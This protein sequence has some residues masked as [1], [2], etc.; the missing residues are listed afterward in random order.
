MLISVSSI[1]QTK[2]YEPV[3]WK[4]QFWGES[5]GVDSMM[6]DDFEQD[7]TNHL[8]YV[9]DYEII[10]LTKRSMVLLF[11]GINSDSVSEFRTTYQNDT[12]S[13]IAHSKWTNFVDD[14]NFIK[15]GNDVYKKIHKDSVIWSVETGKLTMEPSCGSCMETWNQNSDLSPSY[16]NTTNNTTHY[17]TKIIYRDRIVYK[18]K[19]KYIK[20][21][22]I[23]RVYG[24]T[25]NDKAT[26]PADSTIVEITNG[27]GIKRQIIVSPYY[28][29]FKK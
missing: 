17:K 11:S 3:H 14:A 16:T 27:R 7:T 12:I 6:Y 23:N 5:P 28:I 4:A 24:D 2:N 9:Q 20:A 25:Y 21:Q 29:R 15:V 18:Y 13:F 22:Y 10:S 1:C 19:Y 26:Y 8:C